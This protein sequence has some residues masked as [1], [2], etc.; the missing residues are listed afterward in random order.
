MGGDGGAQDARFE[1]N[2]SSRQNENNLW[3]EANGSGRDIIDLRFQTPLG[4]IAID[5]DE[6]V[7][8]VAP[9]QWDGAGN[10]S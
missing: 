7:F 2:K 6:H 1:G 4:R 5:E 8:E 10:R 3:L 9:H